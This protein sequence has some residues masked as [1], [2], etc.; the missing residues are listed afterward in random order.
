MYHN[1]F[2]FVQ[3]PLVIMFILSSWEASQK[4]QLC[5]FQENSIEHEM[6]KDVP[7]LM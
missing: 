5:V 1:N 2:L 3:I 6:E 7:S 4:C